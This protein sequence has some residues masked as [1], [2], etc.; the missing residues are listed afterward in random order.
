MKTKSI[1]SQKSSLVAI[2]QALSCSQQ[3]L[4]NIIVWKITPLLHLTTTCILH[5]H[6][7]KICPR[8]STAVDSSS[9]VAALLW[10]YVQMSEQ[11]RLPDG[12]VWYIERT[13]N[14]SGQKYHKIAWISDHGAP[15]KTAQS[16]RTTIMATDQTLWQSWKEQKNLFVQTVHMC[17]YLL[18][19]REKYQ[20][21]E[22]SKYAPN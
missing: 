5:G 8:S 15:V 18:T 11:P 10:C 3:T 16:G 21:V 22:K 2:I 13:M 20:A 17:R 12:T 4:N 19:M 9:V 14:Q 6:G 7:P 1:T